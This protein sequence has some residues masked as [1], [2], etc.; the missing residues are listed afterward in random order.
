MVE[1]AEP[2]V[3]PDYGRASCRAACGHARSAFA[4][5]FVG[6]AFGHEVV[7]RDRGCAE[8]AGCGNGDLGV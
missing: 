4:V 7:L 1:Q 6:A 3:A 8:G 5:F 2:V